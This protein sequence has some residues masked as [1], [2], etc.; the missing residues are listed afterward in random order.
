MT[1]VLQLNQGIMELCV[2]KKLP[3]C[4]IKVQSGILYLIS[5]CGDIIARLMNLATTKINVKINVKDIPFIYEKVKSFIEDNLEELL[6]FFKA[7]KENKVQE[8][9]TL[10]N[11]LNLI[12]YSKQ[13][14]NIPVLYVYKKARK[15]GDLINNIYND[16]TFSLTGRKMS[17]D[18]L[19]TISKELKE[20][21]KLAKPVFELF[22]KYKQNEIIVSNFKRKYTT[23]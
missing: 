8:H 19:P 14:N 2:A 15:D 3:E 18:D 5:P 1:T 6:D 21:Q 20:F 10:A 17:K 23:C 13:V 12:A 11:T 9:I 16:G 22:E 7:K 4:Y